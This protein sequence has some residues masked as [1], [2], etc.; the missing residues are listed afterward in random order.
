M[1]KIRV[2]AAKGLALPQ[3]GMSFRILISKVKADS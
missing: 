1:L 3:G 2:T